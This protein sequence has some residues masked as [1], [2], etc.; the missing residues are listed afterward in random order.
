M[1]SRGTLPT[2]APVVVGFNG[3]RQPPQ[4]STVSQ[5]MYSSQQTEQRA[6]QFNNTLLLEQHRLSGTDK[7]D[8]TAPLQQQQSSAPQLT[9]FQHQ[10]L[11]NDDAQNTHSTLSQADEVYQFIID[12]TVAAK[13]E[14]AL[15]ELSRRR[16]SF[17]DLAPILWHSFGVV[18]AVLQ[19]IVS[20]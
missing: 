11:Q 2:A 9:Q 8:T 15:L 19:E 18:T 6:Q 13:R 10:Q 5:T 12:L 4:E 20:I 3:A 7:E 17:A 1:D 14:R 16:E